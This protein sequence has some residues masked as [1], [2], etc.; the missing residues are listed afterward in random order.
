MKNNHDNTGA[1]SALLRDADGVDTQETNS[2]CCVAAGIIAPSSTSTDALIPHE[3]LRG[4]AL[5]DATLN[6]QD[7]LLAQSVVGYA[8]ALGITGFLSEE[9]TGRGYG[10]RDLTRR[11]A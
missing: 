5:T 8:H 11:A 4:A 6:T 7:R 2:L 1:L 9:K 10:A 3:K